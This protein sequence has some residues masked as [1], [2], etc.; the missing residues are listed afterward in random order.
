K[1][2]LAMDPAAQVFFVVIYSE[3]KAGKEGKYPVTVAKIYRSDGL[4]W[5]NDYL[6]DGIPSSANFISGELSISTADALV[7]TIDKNGKLKQ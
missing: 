5:Q 6:V 2:L 4:A 3:S 1:S 7:Y